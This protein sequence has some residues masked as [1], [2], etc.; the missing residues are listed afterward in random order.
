[1]FINFTILEFIKYFNDIVNF[2]IKKKN[3]GI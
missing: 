3:I 2:L 1:M